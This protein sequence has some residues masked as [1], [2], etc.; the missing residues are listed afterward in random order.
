MIA[1]PIGVRIWIAAGHTD[2]RRGMNRLGRGVQRR[3]FVI[4]TPAILYIFRGRSGSLIKM[5]SCKTAP[6]VALSEAAGARQAR[7]LLGGGRGKANPNVTGDFDLDD[8]FF[9]LRL[10]HD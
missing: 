7:Q 10:W 3:C 5:V 1:L 2:M 6:H 9:G 8:R 4:C